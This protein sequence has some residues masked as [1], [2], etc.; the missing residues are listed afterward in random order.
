MLSSTSYT[1]RSSELAYVPVEPL[2]GDGLSEERAEGIMRVV[3]GLEQ[4]TDV[5]KVWTNYAGL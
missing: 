3:D 2:D 5:V 1:V 4:E